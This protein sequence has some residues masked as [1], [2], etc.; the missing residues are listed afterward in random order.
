MWKIHTV[1]IAIPMVT[2]LTI[3]YIVATTL[4]AVDTSNE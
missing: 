3:T 4:S 1:L 2:R